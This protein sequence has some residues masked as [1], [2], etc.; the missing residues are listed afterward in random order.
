MIAQV[1]KDSLTNIFKWG[2]ILIN[3]EYNIIDR[4]ENDITDK[5]LK[6]LINQKLYKIIL[7]LEMSVNESK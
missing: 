3:I 1:L 6:D 4:Y 2:G 7:L 5:A